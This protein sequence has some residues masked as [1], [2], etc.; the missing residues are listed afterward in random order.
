M[1]VCCCPCVASFEDWSSIFR[2]RSFTLFKNDRDF[3]EKFDSVAVSESTS[4]TINL[5]VCC[6]NKPGGCSLTSLPV[7]VCCSF[8]ERRGY[9]L[10]FRSGFPRAFRC[11]QGQHVR[12]SHTVSWS[13]IHHRL[14]FCHLLLLVFFS[15]PLQDYWWNWSGGC[16]F[17]KHKRWVHPSHVKFPLVSMSANW[18]M[19]VNVFKLYLGVQID[20]IESRAALWFL[21]TCLIVGL[22]PFVIILITASLSSKMYNEAS[23]REEFTFQEIKSTLFRSSIFPWILSRWRF[24][25]VSPYLIILM[26]VPVKNCDDQTP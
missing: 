23:L 25:R 4:P 18:F 24:F 10:T 11:S 26:R 22:L 13:Q 2:N 15:T 3:S 6:A 16:F 5:S 7:L 17:N 20:S 1:N 8:H 19:G 12:I 14:W 21:E 9:V